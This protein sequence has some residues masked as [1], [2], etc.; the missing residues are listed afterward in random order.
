VEERIGKEMD[1]CPLTLLDT[2]DEP[3]I[4]QAFVTEEMQ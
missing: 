1:G 4:H 3:T 2:L